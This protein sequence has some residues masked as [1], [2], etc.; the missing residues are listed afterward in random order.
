MHFRTHMDPYGPVWARPGPLKSGTSSGK[1]HP[2]FFYVLHFY[3]KSL[4]LISIWRFLI[5]LTCSSDFWP[6]Y[7]SGRLWNYLKKQV[8]NQSMHYWYLHHPALSNSLQ[9]G[10]TWA[11]AIWAGHG[12]T[13]VTNNC[14][15]TRISWISHKSQATKA[16]HKSIFKLSC[17]F[18]WATIAPTV[19][20][21]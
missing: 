20:N 1:T 8:W 2:F 7:A 6:K 19:Q 9:I 16:N 4:F 3:Q 11:R 21:M 12:Q 14:N 5:V 18:P 15:G 13:G 17:I 10:H